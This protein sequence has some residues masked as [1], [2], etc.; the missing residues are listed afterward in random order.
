M[1]HLHRSR[2]FSLIELMIGMGLG[3]LCTLVIATVLSNAEGNRRGTTSGSDAQISGNLALFTLQTEMAMA[4]YGFASENPAVG[5]SLVARRG[6]APAAG[7]P[8]VLAPIFITAGPETGSDAIRV[9]ASSKAIDADPARSSSVGYTVPQRLVS[10]YYVQ[11]DKSFQVS[12]VLSYAQGDLVV[13]VVNEGLPCELFQ[14][15]GLP[16]NVPAPRLPRLDDPAG[17]NDINF[18]TQTAQGP[19]EKA[20]DCPGLPV[21]PT[22]SFLVNLGHIIDREY[23]VDAGQLRVSE[24]DTRDMS[25]PI[26]TIQ[27]GIVMIKAYY[28]H[29]TD[30]DGAVDT[31]NKTTPVT[32]DGWRNVLSARIVV[33]AR[34]AHFEK[35]EVTT[36]KLPWRV[37]TASDTVGSVACGNSRCVE[38]DLSGLPDWKHYRY[39]A[40]DTVVPLRNQRMKSRVPT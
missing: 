20:S 40:F 36:A 15:N 12:S 2:G 23:T 9:V 24:L 31:Y 6:G 4:G 1:Q 19:C 18:P 11:G 39:R 10:S 35:E 7:L 32:Q 33:V 30:N 25:R 21:N 13:M 22:G 5:C 34:S 17:W 3:L 26:R 8:P 27:G 16:V 37:G 29:D 38:L 14:L 28:G